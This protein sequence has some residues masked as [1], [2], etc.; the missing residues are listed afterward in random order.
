MSKLLPWI[1]GGAVVGAGLA[2]GLPHFSAGVRRS[3]RHNLQEQQAKKEMGP[4]G[5]GQDLGPERFKF[6]SAEDPSMPT[7]TIDDVYVARALGHLS[8]TEVEELEAFQGALTKDASFLQG[9][10]HGAGVAAATA[11]G[12]LAMIG[13]AHGIN[14]M[15]DAMTFD[16][17]LQAVMKTRPELSTYPKEQVR[18]VYQSLRRLSPQLAKD[19]L[20]AGTYLLRQFERRNPSDPHS[21]PTVELETARTLTQATGELSKRRD[22]VRDTLLEASRIGLAASRKS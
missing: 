21:L 22:T 19:P 6:A 2:A 12:G 16:K 5:L 14:N 1:A 13:A 17:D 20:T 11:V 8:E 10:Q 18:Q 9:L 7:P 3:F 4:L 15:Y